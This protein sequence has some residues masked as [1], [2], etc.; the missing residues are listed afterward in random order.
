MQSVDADRLNAAY[1]TA[2]AALVA[3]RTEEGIWV[4][5]LST[6]ALSTATAVSALALVQREREPP[7]PHDSLIENGLR[8]LAEHQN[9]DGGWGDTV[10]SISNISTAMLCRAAF[11][12]TGTAG[13]YGDALHK[14]G[15]YLET[16]GKDITEQAAALRARY[17]KDRTFAVPILTTCAI[18]GLVSWDEVES[19]PFE[20]AC[21]PQEW[22]R[23]VRLHVVSYAL[24]ALIAVGQAIYH[25]RRPR[26]PVIRLLRWVSVN[27]TLRVL[28]NIQPET[29]GF[30]EATPLTSFVVL[31][32]ASI[33]QHKHA[34]ARN[35]A[36]FLVE[37][38]RPDGSWPIDTNLSTWVTTLAVNALSA[39]GELPPSPQPSP[40]RGEGD[41]LQRSRIRSWLTGQQYTHRH[42]YTGADPGGWAWTP[43]SGGV[44]DADDSPGA[45]LALSRLTDLVPDEEPHPSP[46][47]LARATL[48]DQPE[49]DQIVAPLP[50]LPDLAWESR[51][52]IFHGLWWLL[53][54]Q[55]SDGGW[56][57]FCRGW[58]HLP[59]DRSGTDLT[60]HVLRAFAAW[61]SQIDTDQ[62]YAT[63]L[64]DHGQTS[65]FTGF[66]LPDVTQETKRGLDY[67]AKQQRPDG[68][69][70]PLWFGNQ[71]SPGD[72]NPTYGTAKVL[73]VYR[74]LGLM[75]SEPARRGL[76]W[77]LAAQ[78]AD[79]GW[80]G[81]AGVAS[82]LEET[83]LAVEVL[84]GEGSALSAVN[85]G[86]AWLV[87]QVEAGGLK[88]PTPIGF[89][90]A[91]LWYFEK[92][93]P[94]IF[95]VAALGCA[96]R[97]L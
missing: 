41:K 44:P 67:L 76:G 17:G 38:V 21:L 30:L 84:L 12:I 64:E 3:E 69:W 9:A 26:N 13:Q 78:N 32:L 57:T 23:L 47:A 83:A 33:G 89:Y 45:L 29:G 34:V 62:I 90:F 50:R 10:R 79:G 82:S 63:V 68:S 75:R 11:H 88:N 61:K 77:L 28:E 93:Y 27:R 94:I 71:Y 53:R 97:L 96:R 43:L 4:G 37:S 52:A 18:A 8:W 73:A 35:G 24:P 91:K 25:H 59:F 92:L 51:P 58:G 72:E 2:L 39:A 80:G 7:R 19:L 20:L 86:L 70:L 22:Y 6:S 40:A 16:F 66:P 48:R 36:R 65:K 46:R 55:N 95:T 1:Q 87:S 56:P 81:A 31:S 54:L 49:G 74:D 42:P 85:N 14:V 5:E 15:K 60:A